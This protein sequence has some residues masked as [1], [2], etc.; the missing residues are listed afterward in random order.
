M[1]PL[2]LALLEITSI[3]DELGVPHMLIGGLA[4]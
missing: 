4:V 1:T 3:L 2:E